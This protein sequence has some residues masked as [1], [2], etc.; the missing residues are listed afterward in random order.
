MKMT[1]NTILITGGSSGIGRK[2]AEAFHYWYR[3][4]RGWAATEFA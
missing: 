4:Y 1:G 3:A 2:L